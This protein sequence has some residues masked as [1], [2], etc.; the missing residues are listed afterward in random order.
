VG[1]VPGIRAKKKKAIDSNIGRTQNQH[2]QP[3]PVAQPHATEVEHLEDDMVDWIT[4]SQATVDQDISTFNRDDLFGG[5]HDDENVATFNESHIFDPIA[6]GPFSPT[7]NEIQTPSLAYNVDTCSTESIN[8]AIHGSSNVHDPLQSSHLQSIGSVAQSDKGYE[9]IQ[10]K[11]NFQNPPSSSA[12]VHPKFDSQCVLSCTEIVCNLESY[13]MAELKAPDI[14]LG[15]VKQ[16]VA[17]LM[18]LVAIQQVKHSFRCI[19]LLSVIIYQVIELLEYGC[20]SFLKEFGKSAQTNSLL[21]GKQPSTLSF[22]SFGFKAEEQRS[23][24]VHLFIKELNQCSELLQ[25]IVTVANIASRTQGNEVSIDHK[26]CFVVV[27][28]RLNNLIKKLET[29]KEA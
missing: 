12:Y 18:E 22:G 17:Q 6:H 10:T 21:L 25:R 27:E 2:I 11:S 3:S 9:T 7:L 1:K 28:K 19:A 24:R 15:I 13:I 26:D 29:S 14:V 16:T 23:F 8:T 4:S 20:T 5:L